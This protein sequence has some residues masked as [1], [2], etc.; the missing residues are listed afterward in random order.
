MRRHIAQL[1]DDGGFAC[2]VRGAD[3]GFHFFAQ[4]AINVRPVATALAGFPEPS[5]A[6]RLLGFI[7][8]RVGI[9]MRCHRRFPGSDFGA[10]FRLSAKI[11]V[12]AVKGICF[13]LL[14][15]GHQLLMC[16]TGCRR[17]HPCGS[18]RCTE[19]HRRANVSVQQKL[20]L[21]VST[22]QLLKHAV[23]IKKNTSISG[24]FFSTN[25]FEQVRDTDYA[26]D[27]VVTHT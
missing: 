2:F 5:A 12:G 13:M 18:A 10:T 9:K 4:P 6:G 16:P 3:V 23:T 15:K 17:C 8:I 25:L 22:L 21:R 1:L 24:I 7:V 11:A 14:G 26:I 19:G 20:H 27:R